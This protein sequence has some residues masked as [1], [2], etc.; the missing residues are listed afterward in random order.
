MQVIGEPKGQAVLQ[1]NAEPGSQTVEAKLAQQD[2]RCRPIGKRAHLHPMVAVS[3][4]PEPVPGKVVE[5]GHC[6]GKC[7][8]GIGLAARRFNG[9]KQILMR[10]IEHH[11]VDHGA[12][13]ADQ[14]KLDVTKALEPLKQAQ[15]VL[16]PVHAPLHDGAL[17]ASAKAARA[18]ASTGSGAMRLRHWLSPSQKVS[19]WL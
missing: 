5:G 18:L 8:R 17:A 11:Q 19:R 16:L 1:D 15:K 13:G 9:A 7:Q 10:A 3:P 12:T 14:A 4:G 6:D 2:E